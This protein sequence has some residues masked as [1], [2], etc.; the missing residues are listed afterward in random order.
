MLCVYFIFED[1]NIFHQRLEVLNKIMLYSRKLTEHCKPA[2]MKK[3]KI[4]YIYKNKRII[5]KNMEIL[6]SEDKG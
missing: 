3:I 2:T 4:L 5:F 1:A 6:S